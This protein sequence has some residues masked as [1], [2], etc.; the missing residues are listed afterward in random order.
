MSVNSYKQDEVQKDVKKSA[1]LWRLYKYL[2]VYKKKKTPCGVFF[3]KQNNIN[4]KG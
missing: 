4:F 2:F 3:L 1:T